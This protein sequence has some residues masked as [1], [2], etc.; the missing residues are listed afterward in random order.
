MAEIESNG[1]DS[2]I[3]GV[4]IDFDGQVLNRKPY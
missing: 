2:P 1:T 3:T 4:S